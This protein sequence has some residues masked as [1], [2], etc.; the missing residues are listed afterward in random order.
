MVKK[1]LNGDSASDGFCLELGVVDVL[2]VVFLLEFFPILFLVVDQMVD[3][4]FGSS[5]LFFAT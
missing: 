1:F 4:F 2:W 5:L 3:N